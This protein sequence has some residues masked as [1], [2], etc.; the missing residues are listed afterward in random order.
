MEKLKLVQKLKANHIYVARLLLNCIK[1]VSDM[2]G[3]GILGDKISKPN[4]FI[5]KIGSVLNLGTIE[6]R[7]H[8]ICTPINISCELQFVEVMKSF[9]VQNPKWQQSILSV[10]LNLTTI[11]TADLGVQLNT[12]NKTANL[13]RG[14]SLCLTQLVSMMDN[15]LHST[16]LELTGQL[17]DTAKGLVIGHLKSGTKSPS[18]PQ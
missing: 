12:H 16:P 15:D 13:L 4:Q 7:I 6:S 3:S 8:H 2:M 9:F 18:K 14:H 5:D 17:W 11:Y 10:L 1:V